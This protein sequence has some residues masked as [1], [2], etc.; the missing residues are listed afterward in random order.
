VSTAL[1]VNCRRDAIL[2]AVARD[3]E[4]VD[5][6]PEKLTAPALL[7][8]TERL[9]AMLDAIA[10]VLAE[11][12]PAVVRVLMPEQTYDDSYM[13]IAPRATLETLVRLAAHAAGVPVQMVHRNT[14][15][16]RLG[17]SRSGSFD[18]QIPATV[19]EPVGKY[20]NAGRSLAAAA[21]LAEDR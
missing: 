3:G 11:V 9:P 17:M 16:T 13:R 10:R 12:R 5:G 18:G 21:A 4:L 8:E 2:L 1:G 6:L 7:E 15:R 20:W 19:G 14:A